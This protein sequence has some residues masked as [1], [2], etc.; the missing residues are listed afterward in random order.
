MSLAFLMLI[1]II[2]MLFT[3]FILHKNVSI[4]EGVAILIVGT[5]VTVGGW[6][7]LK[8]QQSL[9]FELINGYIT[10]KERS[11]T[12]CEHSYECNCEDVTYGTGENEYTVSECSVCYEHDNDWDWDILTNTEHSITIDRIDRRGIHAPPRWMS[13]SVGDGVSIEQQYRN[14]IKGADHTILVDRTIDTSNVIIPTYPRVYD[15]YKVDR[16]LR[17]NTLYPK[18][19]E[20]WNQR[21]TNHL[22]STGNAKWSNIIIVF[23]SYSE[24][25]GLAIKQEWIGG[26]SNDTVVVI[27]VDEVGQY[28]WSS[29]FGW[30]SSHTLYVDI[31][32]QLSEIEDILDRDLVVDT[33]H[34]N[35]VHSFNRRSMKEFAYLANDFNPSTMQLLTL[36]VIMLLSL[37]GV[38]FYM[39]T[40]DPFDPYS[41]SEHKW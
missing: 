8:L 10:S 22:K 25:Y 37:S 15:Y 17:V 23:T 14:Y 3:H 9:D 35:V 11:W 18:Q 4:M 40:H 39:I 21:L 36:I 32:N 28:V 26:K 12:S 27:G 41:R 1:P 2:W 19:V 6:Y 34:N 30:S 16:V 7:G 38:T 13:A 20:D 29:A 5:L 31:K 24:S 33:I